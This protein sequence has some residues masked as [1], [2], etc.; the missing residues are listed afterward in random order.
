[1]SISRQALGKVLVGAGCLSLVL[2]LAGV[3]VGYHL[4][5]QVDSSVDDS[6]TLT[7]DALHAVSNTI[8]VSKTMVTSVRD[9]LTTVS[10]TLRSVEQSL[11]AS[12]GTLDGVQLF[13]AG[14][15]PDSIDAVNQV[16]PTLVDVAGNIDDALRA[17]SNVPFGPD[18]NPAVPF[19]EA[20]GN[21]SIALATLPADLRTLSRQFDDFEVAAAQVRSDLGDLASV[22]DG[23]SKQIDDVDGLLDEYSVTTAQAEVLARQSRG[24]L[25]DSAAL[26]KLMVVLLGIVFAL[27]QIVP[28]WLGRTLMSEGR[29]MDT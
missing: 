20:V 16:L 8:E 17:L 29:P 10:A 6:L 23:L 15:L 21:L 1:M 18:Y 24:D 2:S 13:L 28:I 11:D 27:G 4:V 26:A 22:V 12:T 25:G 19:D 3:A 9:G 7:G 14:S 5:G